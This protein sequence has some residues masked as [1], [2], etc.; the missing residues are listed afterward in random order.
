MNENKAISKSRDALY[1]LV[2]TLIVAVAAYSNLVKEVNHVQEVFGNAQQA[3]S[4]GLGSLAKVYVAMR[5]LGEQLQPATPQ[6]ASLGEAQWSRTTPIVGY[7][8][9]K[10]L[11][12][13]DAEPV[14]VQEDAGS[15]KSNRA[16]VSTSKV[17]VLDPIES[18]QGLTA[19]AITRSP[20]GGQPASC[21]LAKREQLQAEGA[22]QLR[23]LA[24]LPHRAPAELQILSQSVNAE[25]LVAALSEKD[26]PETMQKFIRIAKRSNSRV[27]FTRDS[28][29][30]GDFRIFNHIVA[31]DP[32]TINTDSEAQILT[33]GD[34]SDVHLSLPVRMGAKHV[35]SESEN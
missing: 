24:Q 30:T 2:I 6:L 32:A 11:D 25:A 27:R 22:A 19:R 34:S 35:S 7:I 13:V 15:L 20:S 23:L 4:Q 14:S 10:G 31:L 5:T 16:H 9:L 3:T 1:R 8:E 17:V 28:L 21:D 33:S 18:L 26:F 29:R 12:G